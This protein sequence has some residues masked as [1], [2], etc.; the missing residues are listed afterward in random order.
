MEKNNP[1]GFQLNSQ[2]LGNQQADARGYNF[3]GTPYNQAGQAMNGGYTQ[4][5]MNANMFTGTV[6]ITKRKKQALAISFG[7]MCAGLVISVFSAFMSFLFAVVIPE[8]WIFM[9]IG[10][11][12]LEI[13]MVFAT[14]A[15]VRHNKV[16]LG[17]FCY[18][19]FAIANGT[20]FMSIFL[21]YAPSAIL[22]MFLV[23]AIIFGAA[24]VAAL[25]I[26]GDMSRMQTSLV[27]GLI[28]LLIM[29][30]IYFIFPM[31]ILDMFICFFGIVLFIVITV[32]DIKKIHALAT[33]DTQISVWAVGLFGGIN[34]YLDFVNLLLKIL[35]IFGRRK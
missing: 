1:Y 20:T 3:N 29:T 15:C 23:T 6:D 7:I 27:M 22:A 13:G 2:E 5:G 26:P 9:M 10:S 12:V 19:L 18:I 17:I 4:T 14:N 16:G 25:I 11:V 8:I 31:P 34:L 24:T 21:T 35:R 33:T 30:L 32:F 28:A